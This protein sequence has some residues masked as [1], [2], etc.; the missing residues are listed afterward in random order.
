[1]YPDGTTVSLTATAAA[2]SQFSGWSGACAGVAAA[3]SIKL[4]G[5]QAVTAS[6]VPVATNHAPAPT[7]LHLRETF[8]TF[9]VAA[10]VTPL[11]ASTSS[12]HHHRGTI[13]SFVLD[14]AATVQI[15]IEQAKRGRKVA[16]R[17]IASTPRR[18]AKRKCTL[19]VAIA[20]LSRPLPA[21]ADQVPFS[22]RL[23]RR[24][25]KPGSYTA[26]FTASNANGAS[27][28]AKLRFTIVA[29]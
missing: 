28:A 11:I 14:Q 5:D 1:M 29:R 20:T 4:G 21:G 6:F 10:A 16:G 9:A 18:R 17:C 3:C 25:L 24:R 27:R 8:A 15:A 2:G 23:G 7:L 13:F 19:T 22:G 26:T 12:R